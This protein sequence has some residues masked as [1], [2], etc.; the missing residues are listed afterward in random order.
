MAEAAAVGLRQG[1][2]KAVFIGPA[3][4]HPGVAELGQF[5]DLVAAKVRVCTA[6]ALSAPFPM[7][8]PSKKKE[9]LLR[10]RSARLDGARSLPPPV[11]RTR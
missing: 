3:M 2:P 11:T 1:D 10:T 9:R 5:L 8:L 7:L 6:C 4:A